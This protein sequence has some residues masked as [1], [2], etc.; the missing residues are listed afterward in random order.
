[1]LNVEFFGPLSWGLIITHIFLGLREVFK[2]SNTCGVINTVMSGHG[3]SSM[4]SAMV[5]QLS[6][7]VRRAQQ[8]PASFRFKSA[9]TKPADWANHEFRQA[10]LPDRR[11]HRRLVMMATAFAQKPTASIPQACPNGAEVK[12]AYRFLENEAI[13]PQALRQAHHQSTLER[14]RQHRL[15]LAVQ[16]TTAL[17]YSTHPQTKGLGPLGSHS[18]NTIG[19][20]LHSTLALTPTGQPLGFL[21]NAVRVRRGQRLATSR[22]QRELSQK[23]SY[24]WVESLAACQT[25]APACPTTQLV[26]VADRE[27]DLFELFAQALKVPDAS[28]VHLLVRARHD[29]KLADREGKLWQEVSRQRVAATLSVMVG[30]KGDQPSRVARLHIRFCSVKLR[31]PGGDSGQCPLQIWAIEAR[32]ISAPDGTTPILWQLLTTL[33]VTTAQEAMEKAGWYAQRWQIEVLH[34]VLKSGCQIEQRQM[35]TA[36]RLDRVLSIDLVVA[37]RILALCKAARE[38]PEDPIS[39]WLPAAQWQALCCYVYQ[40]TTPPK[41]PPGVRQAVRWIAQ[42]GGFL[43]RKHDGEPGTK[44]L[45]QGMQQLEAITSMWQLFHQK[46][47]SK[48]CG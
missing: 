29:R 46:K 26:N 47:R 17:N 43:A 14:V 37:W 23:E 35:E 28:R 6:R 32:E 40:R 2:C 3:S 10:I 36:K 13:C 1:M 16:D 48:K 18:P 15:V 8:V 9:S 21:H 11:H 7:G 27:G 25:L 33:P 31:A 4:T 20:F 12:A 38:L 41:K 30:R 44:T 5:T 45:W 22:H 34:K 42:L 19:L 39:D 24:K